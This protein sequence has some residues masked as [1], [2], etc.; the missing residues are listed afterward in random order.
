MNGQTSVTRSV[1]RDQAASQS[2]VDQLFKR[3]VGSGGGG[4]S[5]RGDSAGPPDRDDALAARSAT[6]KCNLC[7]FMACLPVAWLFWERVIP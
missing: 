3:V 5:G 6:V 7:W 1:A 2:G 4:S